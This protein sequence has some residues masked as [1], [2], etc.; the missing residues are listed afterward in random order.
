MNVKKTFLY[1]LR[2]GEFSLPKT[3]WLFGVFANIILYFVA[4]LLHSVSFYRIV[5]IEYGGSVHLILF[6]IY[7]IVIY[8]Y[9]VNVY[10]GV[11]RAANKYTGDIGWRFFAKLFVCIWWVVLALSVISTFGIFYNMY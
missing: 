1:K 7:N 2:Q 3:F 10:I 11:W 9:F 5:N 6:F 4:I 8:I